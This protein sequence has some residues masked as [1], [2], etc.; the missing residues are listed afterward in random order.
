MTRSPAESRATV[1]HEIFEIA[2]VVNLRRSAAKSSITHGIILG[3][4]NILSHLIGSRRRAA[5]GKSFVG[6]RLFFSILD[7][8]NSL[9]RKSRRAMGLPT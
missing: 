9:C 8:P 7:L 4:D 6:D 3:K 2:I 5:V 1:V